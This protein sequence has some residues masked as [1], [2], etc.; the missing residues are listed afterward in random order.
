M[1]LWN[2]KFTDPHSVLRRDDVKPVTIAIASIAIDHQIGLLAVCLLLPF[3]RLMWLLAA[4]GW[5]VQDGSGWLGWHRSGVT[6]VARAW[7]QRCQSAVSTSET[8]H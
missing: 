6:S 1:V 7:V 3:T 5:G 8:D 2:N 4:D